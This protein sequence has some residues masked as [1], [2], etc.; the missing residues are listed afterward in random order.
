MLELKNNCYIEVK[1]ILVKF[2]EGML[3]YFGFNPHGDASVDDMQVNTLCNDI[4]EKFHYLTIEE[5]CL[6]FKKA[7][8]NP[9]KYGKFYGKF[10]A[11]VVMN[12]F[13]MY[14]SER[15]EIVEGIPSYQTSKTEDSISREDYILFLQS[16]QLAGDLTV[17]SSLD[18]IEETHK[19]LTQG[20]QAYKYQREH[21]FD[22]R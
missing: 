12:W 21:K 1:A 11:S 4:L 3:R 18:M 13:N 7:R 19:I 10:D 5:V 16:C 8:Q 15:S 17:Q 22:K 2:I 14:D 6:C 20:Y 9:L